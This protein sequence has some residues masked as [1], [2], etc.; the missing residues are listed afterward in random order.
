VNARSQ[1]A[2]Y[3][4]TAR[5]NARRGT[6][7][8]SLSARRVGD[9][10]TAGRGDP[11]KSAN[12]DDAGSR[13]RRNPAPGRND[14]IYGKHSVR[15]VFRERP[16]TVRRVAIRVGA[17]GYLQE[18]IDLSREA[19]IE[20]ELM[21]TGEFLRLGQLDENDKHQGV[22]VIAD[23]L[24]IYSEYD[25]DQLSQASVVIVLDQLS[26][27]QNFGTIIRTAAFFNV[28]GVIW[29]KDRAVDVDATVMRIAV[30]G[31]EMVRLF[32]V[33]NLARTLDLLKERGFWVYGFDE[34]GEKSLPEAHF[35]PKSALVFGAEGEGLRQRTKKFCDELIR[36]DGGRPGLES[37]NAGVAAG[38]VMAEVFRPSRRQV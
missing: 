37:L 22:F 35:A 14:V 33:T 2:A 21:R 17:A 34:R 1:P 25:F 8:Q 10:G 11:D 5:T 18:F 31:T 13:G 12:V 24:P 30:G 15:A 7:A 38:I 26:N 23:P 29:L 32:R 9:V 20:P 36:I 3:G 27:P 16:G 4:R 19:G 28:D 6:R